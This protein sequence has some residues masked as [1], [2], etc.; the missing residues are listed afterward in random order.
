MSKERLSSRWPAVAAT[1]MLIS[2]GVNG[3]GVVK[4]HNKAVGADAA[5]LVFEKLDKP[6]AA[7]VLQE[8]SNSAEGARTQALVLTVMNLGGA[9]VFGANAMSRRREQ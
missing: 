4:Q 6:N 5:S 7:A 8:A 3:A 9:A 1:A 2:A